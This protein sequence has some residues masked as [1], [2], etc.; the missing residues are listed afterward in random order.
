M[1]LLLAFPG[2]KDQFL[3]IIFKNIPFRHFLWFATSLVSSETPRMSTLLV[4]FQQVGVFLDERV[5]QRLREHRLVDLVVTE[6]R[7][8]Q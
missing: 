1:G 3:S 6:P 5:H 4:P 8:I 7:K 2:D